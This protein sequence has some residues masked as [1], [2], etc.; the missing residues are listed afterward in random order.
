M[1]RLQHKVLKGRYECF[2]IYDVVLVRERFAAVRNILSPEIAQSIKGLELGGFP[3]LWER[4]II[5]LLRL[6]AMQWPSMRVASPYISINTLT[7]FFI[8]MGVVITLIVVT[9][10]VEVVSDGET[11]RKSWQSG[12]NV[13]TLCQ[14]SITAG[15]RKLCKNL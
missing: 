12:R 8:T 4:G 5:H 2:A 1:L 3:T 7:D 13:C 10:I 6:E 9:F 14:S 15:F 11:R